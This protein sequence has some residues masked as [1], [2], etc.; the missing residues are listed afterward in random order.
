[1]S[2]CETIAGRH[3]GIGRVSIRLPTPARCEHRHVGDDLRGASGDAR[4]HADAFSTADDE[5]EHACFLD[6]S[7]ALTLV[8]TIDESA[9]DLGAGL[10]AV[11]VDD[12]VLRVRRLTTELEI[13]RRIEVEVR[14][15][16]LQLT[17]ARRPFLDKYL[18][19]GGVTERRARS[20]CVAPVQLR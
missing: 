2:N 16:S 6:D 14:P 10:I 9:R 15:G 3:Y 19:G 1:M 7:D 18:D 13:P 17:H 11:C 5:V 4:T 8:D 12:A 20:E